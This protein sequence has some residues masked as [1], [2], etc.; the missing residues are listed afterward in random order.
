MDLFGPVFG[1]LWA[2]FWIALGQFLD[3]FGPIIVAGD[4]YVYINF[5]LV[6]KLNPI[7]IKVF[8]LRGMCKY[9]SF[10]SET[11]M[12]MLNQDKLIQDARDNSSPHFL[13]SLGGVG[14]TLQ[15]GYCGQLLFPKYCPLCA[16]G[17]YVCLG[18]SCM[19]ARKISPNA[20]TVTL[21]PPSNSIPGLVIPKAKV[22]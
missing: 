13:E 3:R 18:S 20:P 22:Q 5:C 16:D 10:I 15:R 6:C 12:A 14:C 11:I 7:T 17:K 2:S 9:K 8:I 1:L 19:G 4:P 21:V